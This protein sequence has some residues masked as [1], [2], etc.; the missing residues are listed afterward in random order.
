[1]TRETAPLL[2]GDPLKKPPSTAPSAVA[3]RAKAAARALAQKEAHAAAARHA[4]EASDDEK[5]LTKRAA[6]DADVLARKQAAEQASRQRQIATQERKAAEDQPK[7]TSVGA[8]RIDE[9]CAALY[10]T[11]YRMT[12]AQHEKAHAN[13][14]AAGLSFR[15]FNL[16]LVLNEAPRGWPRPQVVELA[17]RIDLTAARN[18]ETMTRLANQVAKVASTMEA[19]GIIV[20]K[21]V[22]ELREAIQKMNAFVTSTSVAA[23][24]K[25]ELIDNKH[26]TTAGAV[27][28]SQATAAGARKIGR[29]LLSLVRR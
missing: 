18:L 9:T 22:D 8:R 23:A 25:A 1:M 4:S 16:S 28:L 24:P 7:L 2:P 21:L 11:S 15:D 5:K 10:V 6:Y 17:S 26:A 14:R 20:R 29:G 12:K 19:K 27:G 3:R 13:A